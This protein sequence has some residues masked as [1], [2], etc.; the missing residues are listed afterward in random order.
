MKR[1]ELC[2]VGL[3]KG[4]SIVICDDKGALDTDDTIEQV[5]RATVTFEDDRWLGEDAEPS[6]EMINN[7]SYA[8]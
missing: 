6:D 5:V 3:Q 7:K 2:W 4:I 8:W 1:N